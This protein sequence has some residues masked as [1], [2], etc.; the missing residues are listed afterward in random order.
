[1]GA[2]QFFNRP[3]RIQPELPVGELEIPAPPTPRSGMGRWGLVTLGLPLIT[4]FAYALMSA[5]RG[6]NALFILPMAIAMIVS[7]VVGVMNYRRNQQQDELKQAQYLQRLGE[8]RGQMQEFHQKQSHFYRYT[9]PEPDSLA[10]IVKKPE[11]RLWERRPGDADFVSLRIGTGLIPSSMKLKLASTGQSDSPLLPEA[12]KLVD[13]FARVKDAAVSISLRRTHAIGVTS[14]D[15]NAAADFVRAL[16]VH[17][18][19]LHAPTET[20]LYIVGAPRT[21]SKWQWAR[22]LPH[23]TRGGEQDKS[24]QLSFSDKQM[25]AFWEEIQSTLEVRRTHKEDSGEE[26]TLPFLVVVVDLFAPLNESP[27]DK[28]DSEAA[29]SLLL[30]QG[31][32]LGAAV[33]FL[34]P[35]FK[36][37]PSECN[38]VIELESAA[39]QLY[40]RYAEVGVNSPRLDGAADTLSAQLA[41]ASIARPMSNLAVRTTYGADLPF[42]LHLLDMLGVRSLS[43]LQILENWRRSRQPSD[44]WPAVEIGV[45][46]GGRRRE[47]TFSALADGNHGMIAGTT[48]AGK[49]E[50]LVTMIVGLALRY[51]PSIVNFV[52]VDYKGGTAFD[53]FRK[54]P[55]VV[56]VITNMQGQAGIR[57]FMALR[58]ELNR[59]NSILTD[60]RAKDIAEYRQN[61]YH[62]KQPLPDLFVIIDEFAEMIKAEPEFKSYLESIALLGRSSGVHLI[63]ATQRPSGVVS[64]QIRANMK[65]RI[66]LRVETADDSRELLG[67]TDAVLLP[68]RIPGR[69]Y[70]QV[71][72]ES[73][74]LV[75]TAFSGAEYQD[76]LPSGGPPVIW[77]DREPGETELLSRLQETKLF[78]AII[79]RTAHLAEEYKDVQRLQKPWH[80]PLPRRLALPD[81]N[82]ALADWLDGEG[83]WQET[84]WS[85]GTSLQA[86]VGKIDQPAVAQQG[87]YS[88]DLSKGHL[89]LFGTSGSGRTTLI[90]TL[91]TSL[92][93]VLP[94][95]SLHCY[96]LDFGGGD[97]SLFR[98]LPHVGAC[99]YSY[100]RERVQR[101]LRFLTAEMTRRQTLFSQAQ[102]TGLAEYN[103]RHPESMQPAIVLVL[104][105][106]AEFRENYND[107]IDDFSG[108][109]LDA[110]SYG[111]HL[112]VSA[113]QLV[114]IPS[115]ILNQFQERVALRLADSSEY[116]SIVGQRVPGVDDDLP[117]RGFIRENRMAIEFQGASPCGGEP[118]DEN[119]KLSQVIVAMQHA[120]NGRQRPVP[121]D[122]L[123]SVITLQSILPSDSPPGLQAVVGV[124]DNDLQPVTIDLKK[125]GSHF[126]IVGPPASGKT[127]AMRTL[128]LSIAYGYSPTLIRLV[129]VDFQR[130]FFQYGGTRSLSE[131]PHVLASVS[132]SVELSALA[133]RL[134]DEL[135]GR[136]Q[137]G[138]SGPSIA[139]LIDGYDDVCDTL[140]TDQKLAAQLGNMARRYGSEGFHVV[141]AGSSGVSV[142]DLFTKRIK[143]S[144]YGLALDSSEGLTK[145]GAK[146]RSQGMSELPVGRGYIVRAGRSELV[147]VATPQSE[148]REMEDA[149]DDWVALICNRYAERPETWVLAATPDV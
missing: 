136:R 8:I 19:T 107:S 123:R 52:L 26:S 35:V 148:Q 63:L 14:K 22:Q 15:E 112:I 43:E 130:R 143:E 53:V 31:Q 28:A 49:S 50:L 135:D 33:L 59:R 78:H 111:I 46:M 132:E 23:T 69:A 4:V 10:S 74:E 145:L 137:S 126:L 83:S 51:D 108:L 79:R 76:E 101:L 11:I 93:S 37:I 149:L 125:K 110:R 29:L 38:A 117:G 36:E 140:S 113:E 103:M 147:Q 25:P 109:A 85:T 65:F 118:L 70:L 121:I 21:Q 34:A 61:G 116:S 16:I 44:K 146:Q 1:M 127:T 100:E 72:R 55:H 86:V 139:I 90:R 97:L 20:R 64:D 6:M 7:V 60:S 42:P 96:I 9:F 94:P 128:A 18:A 84:N 105:N 39:G 68:A 58:A 141:A 40:F 88:I 98:D 134:Q 124:S 138:I 2:Q 91:L 87:P 114:T 92:A 66:C 57:T 62:L 54:L 77:L 67:R 80:D 5:T 89:A 56:D 144:N 82:P 75:Q 129:L 99:I 115:K 13:D 17:L 3:P 131:L 48:G 122:I 47:L 95:D 119:E 133:T 102:V 41:D 30:Q 12:Q 73:V 120:W 71:G 142:Y 24:N 104:D 27:I 45:L 32:A 81:L 106:Y